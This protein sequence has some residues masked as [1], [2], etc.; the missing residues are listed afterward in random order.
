[1]STRF[2][3]KVYNSLLNVLTF[4]HVKYGNNKL[5]YDNNM[6][7]RRL[8]I[9]RDAEKCGSLAIKLLNSC[10]AKTSLHETLEEL[11]NVKKVM[12][13]LAK[14]LPKPECN[15][16]LKIIDIV[17]FAEDFACNIKK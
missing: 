2:D 17:L 10:Y 13:E 15:V 4:L 14:I 16:L 7:R 11:D 3:K 9:L 5:W 1:M 8:R 12:S 6:E